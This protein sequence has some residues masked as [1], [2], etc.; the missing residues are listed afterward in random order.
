M[1]VGTAVMTFRLLAHGAMPPFLP[2]PPPSPRLLLDLARKTS[3]WYLTHH[4]T[5]RTLLQGAARASVSTLPCPCY[6]YTHCPSPHRP[7]PHRPSPHRLV[8]SPRPLSSHLHAFAVFQGHNPIVRSAPSVSITP[9]DYSP[10]N[11]SLMSA[12]SPAAPAPLSSDSFS[13]HAR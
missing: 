3:Y 1:L 2:S 7:S 11:A 12:I 6:A 9:L 13:S 5:S 8:F 4:Q 10:Y